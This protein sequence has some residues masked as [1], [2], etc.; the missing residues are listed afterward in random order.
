MKFSV[1]SLSGALFDKFLGG[2]GAIYEN[3]GIG[4]GSIPLGVIV[5]GFIIGAIS[6]FI[7]ATVYKKKD[8]AFVEKMLMSGAV[9]RENAKSF[10]DLCWYSYDI[11]RSLRGSER[12]RRVVKSLEEVEHKEKIEAR[13]AAGEAL[14]EED[15]K[16]YKISTTDHFYIPEDM[17]DHAAVH[18][19]TRGTSWVLLVVIIGLCIVAYFALMR[20][21]PRIL[22]LLD[23]FVGSMR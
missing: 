22:T 6:A 1:F 13:K 15:E 4:E 20:W 17:K 8:C 5:L 3:L 19:E 14:S 10:D 18:F 12:L 9:G 7:A 2:D 21:I 23:S 16:P 11:V